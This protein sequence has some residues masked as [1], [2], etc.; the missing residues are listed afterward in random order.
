SIGKAF[1]GKDQLRYLSNWGTAWGFAA[2][3][4]SLV[5][6]DNHDNQ[7][8][9]GAGGADVLTYKVPKQYKMASAFMLAHPFGTPRVMSSFSF[10]D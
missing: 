6:V 7:R 4:R 9:H 3:D 1:R 8:G 10:S 2:S 5:F